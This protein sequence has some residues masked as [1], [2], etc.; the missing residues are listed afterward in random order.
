MKCK[1]C[2]N[3][4]SGGDVFC[5]VCSALLPKQHNNKLS[6]LLSKLKASVGGKDAVAIMCLC[7][8]ILSVLFIFACFCKVFTISG[9]NVYVQ[10]SWY[11]C[12]VANSRFNFVLIIILNVLTDIVLL[13]FILRKINASRLVLLIPAATYIWSIVQFVSRALSVSVTAADAEVPIRFEITT[14]G[15]M[16]LVICTVSLAVLAVVYFKLG[17]RDK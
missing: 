5:P 9:S 8:I 10:L 6:E 17:K 7:E 2:G 14:I 15:W 13:N 1:N 12:F 4:V 11:D 16:I 3:E